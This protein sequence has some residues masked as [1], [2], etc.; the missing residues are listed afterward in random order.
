ME[1]AQA[2][3]GYHENTHRYLGKKQEVSSLEGTTLSNTL[4]D[5]LTRHFAVILAVLGKQRVIAKVH[6]RDL[7][8][9]SHTKFTTVP[10]FRLKRGPM[11]GSSRCTREDFDT[12]FG[13]A[14]CW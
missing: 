11:Y 12:L 3:H 7:I 1:I 14:G 9:A 10:V 5:P 13:E 2:F 6:S 8:S 4:M